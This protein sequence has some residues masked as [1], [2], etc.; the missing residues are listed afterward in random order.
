MIHKWLPYLF[1]IF[2]LCFVD[3][4]VL[5]RINLN[6]ARVELFFRSLPLRLKLEWELFWI[7]R[8]QK[9]YLDMAR[10]IQQELT[11]ETD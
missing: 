5:D 6:V 8:N 1:L 9:K 4:Q 10:K 2:T 11:N 7:K 3:R